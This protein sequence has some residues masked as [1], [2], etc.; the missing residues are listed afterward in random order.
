MGLPFDQAAGV[1]GSGKRLFHNITIDLSGF[2]PFQ[3]YAGFAEHLDNLGMGILGQ[4][5]FF[6]RFKVHFD[7]PQG[8]FEIEG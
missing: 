8:N 3:V 7:L 6:D 1:G 5:G 4:K 2:A